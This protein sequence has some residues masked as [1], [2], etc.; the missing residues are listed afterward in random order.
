MEKVITN[1]NEDGKVTD[2]AIRA[3]ANLAANN[4]NNQAALG[5]TGCCEVYHYGTNSQDIYLSRNI[6]IDKSL[7]K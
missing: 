4:P 6:T 1:F 2:W 7:G 5:A 3:I